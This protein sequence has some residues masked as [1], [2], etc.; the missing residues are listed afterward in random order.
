MVAQVSGSLGDTVRD[1]TLAWTVGGAVRQAGVS[2]KGTSLFTAH[3]FLGQLVSLPRLPGWGRDPVKLPR[4]G[5]GFQA[6]PEA[7]GSGIPPLSGFPVSGTLQSCLQG[8]A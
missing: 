4:P 1:P 2:S 6:S 8:V 5:R 7:Q 3:S